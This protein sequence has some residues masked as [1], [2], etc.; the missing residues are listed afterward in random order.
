MGV[1]SMFFKKGF[2]MYL[3]SFSVALLAVFSMTNL[4][5]AQTSDREIKGV[6]YEG[7]IH[8]IDSKKELRTELTIEELEV[9]D[10]IISFNANA[11]YDDSQIT[12]RS[13]GKVYDSLTDFVTRSTKAKT[14]VFDSPSKD[15]EIISFT[16]EEEAE[17]NL[18]LP[19]NKSLADKTILK[20]AVKLNNSNRL[21]YFEGEVPDL[22]N[23]MDSVSA[24]LDD[25]LS[26]AENLKD[27]KKKNKTLK[28][29]KNRM[30]TVRKNEK[31]FFGY[32]KQNKIQE[33]KEDE[34]SVHL[35]SGSPVPGLQP[36]EFQKVRKLISTSSSDMGYYKNTIEWPYGSGNKL[37]DVFKWVWIGNSPNDLN[38]ARGDSATPENVTLRIVN[39][40]QYYYIGDTREL[41]LY[42]ESVPV[43]LEN[44]EIAVA[45][46]S[47]SGIFQ[48][49]Q[50]DGFRENGQLQIDLLS[51][52]GALPINKYF[53]K[54]QT[55]LPSISF[56][57]AEG[58]DGLYSYHETL[59]GNLAE[60][61]DALRYFNAF[62]EEPLRTRGDYDNINYT[63]VIPEDMERRR[64]GYK[65][66]KFSY[67]F[68]ITVRDFY[69]IW[70]LEKEVFE[71]NS[72][73]FRA[74]EE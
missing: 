9:K 16:V 58:N 4:I 10:G 50:T 52:T 57:P 35:M 65:G 13:T 39:A 27:G 26:N 45:T 29:I 38:V 12:I 53:S 47:Y 23:E 41:I 56:K 11:A 68:D 70:N 8:Q 40:E 44:P 55:V 64:T 7:E 60:F 28:D 74:Y 46:N 32:V 59:A 66:V 49:L 24:N 19:V 1:G 21:L 34:N 63:I 71:E 51:L 67:K 69:G 31:W 37:T 20:L 15:Y 25:R 2:L 43:R 22:F 42:D 48:T 73:G 33:V 61:G 72:G 6:I 36:D 5:Y 54:I 17:K 3:L 14:V 18:L 30:E 62:S